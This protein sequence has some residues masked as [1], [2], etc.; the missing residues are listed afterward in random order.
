MKQLSAV[1][2]SYN[3]EA[4]IGRALESLKGVADE[5]VVVDSFSQDGTERVCRAY[6]DRFF[7]R[8]WGG[9]R[10]QKQHATNQARN[11]WVLSLD[12][13]EALSAGLRD[14][15]KA[16][17]A[18]PESEANGYRLP[19]KT[20]FLG[21][22][23]EHTTWYPDW[24]LRLFRKSKGR[25]TGRSVHESFAVEGPVGRFGGFLEHYTYASI[26]EYLL[27]LERFSGLAASDYHAA[28]RRAGWARLA[29]S[30]PATFLNNY[31][32]RRGFLDGVPGLA[33]SVLS[34][35]SV[36]FKWL[37]LWELQSGLGKG[38]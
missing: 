16:W 4:K 10:E 38:E 22:W 23:I 27:Q 34:A 25:W 18:R 7:Q 32:V 17:K 11:D 28:G 14:E 1:I 6:T 30:P 33:A 21:R 8:E 31:V 5:I 12:A 2:I 19:R 13:D 9:Y 24:Q 37:R 29:L 36:F 35:T 20:F 26:S 15:L 3:E